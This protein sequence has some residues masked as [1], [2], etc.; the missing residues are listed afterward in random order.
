MFPLFS[1]LFLVV[2]PTDISLFLSNY[3][4]AHSLSARS[5][6]MMFGSCAAL[7]ALVGTFDAAGKSLTGSYA[8]GAP[9]L[10]GGVAAEHGTALE[11][12]AG[13]GQRGWREEREARRKSFFK[14]SLSVLLRSRRLFADQS[15]RYSLPSFCTCS[16]DPFCSRRR[17]Q[18]S[19]QSRYKRQYLLIS[20]DSSFMQHKLEG[21]VCGEDLSKEQR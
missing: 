21:G 16:F 5:I 3:D 6:P 19:T 7:A 12:D 1:L 17:R 14:V 15:P 13:H 8:Q 9:G 4:Y 18:T 11:G 20:L 2:L 10:S